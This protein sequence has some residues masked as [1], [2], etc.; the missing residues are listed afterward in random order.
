MVGSGL[1]SDSGSVFHRLASP[2]ANSVTVSLPSLHIYLWVG[3]RQKTQHIPERS[4][5]EGLH[6]DTG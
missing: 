5:T 3:M 4:S 6:P 1:S 2:L